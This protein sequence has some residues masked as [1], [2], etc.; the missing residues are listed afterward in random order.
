MLLEQTNIAVNEASGQLSAHAQT[1]CRKQYRKILAR[2]EK[3]CPANEPIPNKRG[4]TKQPKAR[5]LLDRLHDFEDETLRFITNPIIPF[6]N[7]QAERD[8]RMTKVQQKI[9]GC[10]RSFQ[11]AKI[12]CRIR[13]YISTCI[14]HGLSATDALKILADGTPP[15]FVRRS[16]SKSAE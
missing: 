14:K 6:S 10:F 5:N 1:D 16:A 13:S 11:G 4:K 8:I 9:S 12:F 2:G 15:P 3:E 7:N